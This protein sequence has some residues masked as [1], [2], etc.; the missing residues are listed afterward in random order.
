MPGVKG[1]AA[2]LSRHFLALVPGGGRQ[3]GP[4][5]LGE[6]SSKTMAQRKGNVTLPSQKTVQSRLPGAGPWPPVD[7]GGALGFCDTTGTR[8]Q[9][10]TQAEWVLGPVR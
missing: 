7:G 8:V 3:S 6:V 9:P 10:I 2:A 1:R 4:L 5:Y